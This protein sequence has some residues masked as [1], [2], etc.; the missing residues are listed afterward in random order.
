MS[1]SRPMHNSSRISRRNAH[2]RGLKI[3][4]KALEQQ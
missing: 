4:H 2:N 3:T 1:R